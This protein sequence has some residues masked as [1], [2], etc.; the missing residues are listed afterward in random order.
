M[1]RLPHWSSDRNC[2]G[3]TR[4]L[5]FDS[6]VGQSSVNWHRFFSSIEN[7]ETGSVVLGAADYLCSG[8]CFYQCFGS[9]SKSRDRVVLVQRFKEESDLSA[10]S[11]VEVD[12]SEGNGPF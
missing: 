3:W 8:S 1:K 7:S 11:F 12:K 9:K 5:G 10:R 6:R 4:G 2:D